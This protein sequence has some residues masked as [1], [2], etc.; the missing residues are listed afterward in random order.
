MEMN[1]ELLGEKSASIIIKILGLLQLAIGLFS[2]VL[3]PLEIYSFYLFSEGGRFQYK[4]FGIGSFLFGIIAGQ[5]IAYYAIAILFIA[6]GYGHLKLQRWAFNLSQSCIWFWVIFGLPVLLMISPLISMKDIHIHNPALTLSMFII[7]LIIIIPGL[8]LFFYNQ[9]VVRELFNNEQR[10]IL[11]F[12]QS[13]VSSLI[14]FLILS[15]YIIIFHIMLFFKGLFPFFGKLLID[16]KGIIGYDICILI[17]LFL[18]YGLI[19]R[20]YWSWFLSLSFFSVMII[21]IIITLINYQYSDIIELLGF[22][23]F[24]KDI[25][26]QLPL[27][28]S[29]F[30]IPIIGL[31][32]ITIIL[33]M[34]TRKHY[35]K[36]DKYAI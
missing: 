3:A 33:I 32:L 4:D 9:K 12:E 23:K 1:T 8:L 21:S 15:F 22:P 31:L 17:L 5:I 25:F 30:L 14:L 10:T 18:I 7:F 16:L 29:Y 35:K 19:K 36:V 27:Q 24:E 28:S 13:S 26:I 11:R 34:K 2:L 6:I 20:K